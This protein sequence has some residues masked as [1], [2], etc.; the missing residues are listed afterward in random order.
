MTNVPYLVLA[1]A[2]LWLAHVVYLWS[3]NSRE[4]DMRDQI[5]LLEERLSQSKD[6]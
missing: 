2:G 6:R 4:R 1:Y 3:L 5:A